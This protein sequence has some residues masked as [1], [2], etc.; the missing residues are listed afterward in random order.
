MH[1]HINKCIHYSYQSD[2]SKILPEFTT[3]SCWRKPA[4]FIQPNT[5]TLLSPLSPKSKW[6]TCCR[7][8]RKFHVNTIIL[9]SIWKSSEVISRTNL[10]LTSW[11][12]ILQAQLCWLSKK[13]DERKAA[14]LLI[15]V[16][17]VLQLVLLP[18]LSPQ[19]YLKA[20]FPSCLA[21]LWYCLLVSYLK[22]TGDSSMNGHVG[23]VRNWSKE[24]ICSWCVDLG[25]DRLDAIETA[26]GTV[27]HISHPQLFWSLKALALQRL[28]YS[29]SSPRTWPLHL[30]RK[31]NALL[32]I[33][34]IIGLSEASVMSFVSYF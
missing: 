17:R 15:T 9:K 2:L 6:V 13:T 33:Q 29:L 3:S 34:K 31:E 23:T 28:R 19:Y 22:F 24:K 18:F 4:F 5:C 1:D 30:D 7:N 16:L 27:L 21:T 20:C 26:H 14:I 12:A 25:P 8:T 32:A 11:K 10:T